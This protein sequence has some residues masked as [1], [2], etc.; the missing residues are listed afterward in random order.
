MKFFTGLAHPSVDAT[1][2]SSMATA[3]ATTE[4]QTYSVDSAYLSGS[5]LS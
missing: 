3:S 4:Q 2:V 5:F 1:L